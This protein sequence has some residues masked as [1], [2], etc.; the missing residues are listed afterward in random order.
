M[1]CDQALRPRRTVSRALV[2][3]S[4]AK[5]RAKPSI[6]GWSAAIDASR[7]CALSSVI[8][9]PRARSRFPA[10]ACPTHSTRARTRGISASPEAS[11]ISPPLSSAVSPFVAAP[12][13]DEIERPPYRPEPR[14]DS[15]STSASL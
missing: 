1:Q 2:T 8:V 10:R 11:S 6:M 9:L 3:P 14:G 12:A 7:S 15:S 13:H 4:L 5:L